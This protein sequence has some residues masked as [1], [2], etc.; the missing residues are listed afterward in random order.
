MTINT[1]A[2]FGLER[3]RSRFVGQW[4]QD[5]QLVCNYLGVRPIKVKPTTKQTC[6][7]V[8]RSYLSTPPCCVSPWKSA[9]SLHETRG[10]QIKEWNKLI[11]WIWKYRICS[12][13]ISSSLPVLQLVNAQTFRCWDPSGRKALLWKGPCPLASLLPFKHMLFLGS[14]LKG[15]DRFSF[16][17]TTEL[18]VPKGS[19]VFHWRQEGLVSPKFFIY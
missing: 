2:L 7:E 12:S 11:S 14:W 3:M 18:Q 9:L 5:V 16:L 15:R 10:L 6:T 19:S 8:D 13:P 1:N 4:C 17:I